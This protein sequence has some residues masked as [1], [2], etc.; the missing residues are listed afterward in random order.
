MGMR[1]SSGSF[2]HLSPEIDCSSNTWCM[3][4]A[5]PFVNRSP[6][7]TRDFC[8]TFTSAIVA[9]ARGHVTLTHGDDDDNDAVCGY[10]SNGK[11]TSR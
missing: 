3:Q 2:G 10:N 7:T 5:P 9:S 8:A 11:R 4:N 6:S 1:D